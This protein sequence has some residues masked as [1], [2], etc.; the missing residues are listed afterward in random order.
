[1]KKSK[2]HSLALNK[3]TIS[4]F[5]KISNGHLNELKGGSSGSSAYQSLQGG[6]G[7]TE[8]TSSTPSCYNE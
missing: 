4:N 5:E 6:C 3:K 2:K 1:M 7:T 8:R